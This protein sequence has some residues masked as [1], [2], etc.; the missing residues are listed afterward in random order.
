MQKDLLLRAGLPHHEKTTHVCVAYLKY[1]EFVLNKQ[2]MSD[3]FDKDIQKIDKC[4]I[5]LHI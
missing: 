5:F 1:L 4:Q 3:L 2:S